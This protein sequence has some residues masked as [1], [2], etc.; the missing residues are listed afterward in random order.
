MVTQAKNAH[1]L[2]CDRTGFVDQELKDFAKMTPTRVSS[3]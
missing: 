3:Q 1:L 2:L